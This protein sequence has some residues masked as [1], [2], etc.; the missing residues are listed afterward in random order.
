MFNSLFNKKA[1]KTNE[2]P[3]NVGIEKEYPVLM[4]SIDSSYA[5]LD[6]LC[7]I[8]DGIS[9]ERIGYTNSNEFPNYIDKYKFYLNGSHFCNLF[10]YSYHNESVPIIPVPFKEINQNASIDIFEQMRSHNKAEKDPWLTNLLFIVNYTLLKN[11]ITI[12]NDV[13]WDIEKQNILNEVLNEFGYN[14]LLE[15]VILEEW[16]ISAKDGDRTQKEFK[17]SFVIYFHN[18]LISKH[19]PDFI[20]ERNKKMEKAYDSIIETINRM[21]CWLD[22]DP[23]RIRIEDATLNEGV[24]TIKSCATPFCVIFLSCDAIGRY[25][26][27]FALDSRILEMLPNGMASTLIRRIYDFTPGEMELFVDITSLNFDCIDLFEFKLSESKV[28]TNI[29]VTNVE[30]HKEKSI[31]DMLRKVFDFDSN[32]DP[33]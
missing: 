10:V 12:D 33:K 3:S 32:E 9:Y 28:D 1:N 26:I 30:R 20:Q 11:Q 14:E 7:L 16:N 19:T 21:Q 5:Y 6:S 15:D 24:S 13:K 27:T 25:H 18:N 31:D 4:D 29:K 22:N 2:I 23:L 8:K 17:D